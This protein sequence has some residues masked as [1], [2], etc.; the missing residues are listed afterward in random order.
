MEF[1]VVQSRKQFAIIAVAGKLDMDGKVEIDEM[2]RQS[3]VSEYTVE[4]R[5]QHLLPFEE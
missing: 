4:Q 2:M 5:R 3:D 1:I